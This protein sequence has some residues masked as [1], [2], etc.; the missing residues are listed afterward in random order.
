MY[1]TVFYGFFPML[2]VQLV[3]SLFKYSGYLYDFSGMPYII[4]IIII[5]CMLGRLRSF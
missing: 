5:I 3:D 2:I 1:F 4:I